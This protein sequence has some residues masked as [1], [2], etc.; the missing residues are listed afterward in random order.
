M[1]FSAELPTW[2]L[3]AEFALAALIIVLSG[4]RFVLLAD[5]LADRLNLSGGWIGIVLLASVTSL[6]ELI[7]SATAVS[8]HNVDLA[9]GGILGSCCLNITIIVLLNWR[10]KGGSVLSNVSPSHVLSSSFSLLLIGIALIGIVCMNKFGSM[11]DVAWYGEWVWSGLIVVTY[12][13]CIKMIHRFDK[14]TNHKEHK[15]KLGNNTGIYIQIAL[16]A[17][18]IV[19]TSWWLT[20]LCDTLTTHEIKMIGRPLG[21]TFVGAVFLALVTSLPEITTSFEAVRL[22]NLDMALGNIFGSNM[23]NIFVI[24]VIKV[25]S[26]VQGDSLLM[27]ANWTSGAQ[28]LITGLLAMLLTAIAIGGLAYKSRRRIYGFGFDSLMIAIVYIGGMLLLLI[29][30]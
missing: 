9:F 19:G 25:V 20:Q 7:T 28:N 29:G 30:T 11:P 26:F 16:L 2:A 23:F 12:L 15:E 6:P 27:Q 21:A 18:V 10:M 22:G 3:F 5:K 4:R 17:A 8:I 1:I 13:G 24:P 14:K